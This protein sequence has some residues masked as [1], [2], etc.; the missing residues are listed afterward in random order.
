MSLLKLH[1]R[2]DI[3]SQITSSPNCH[4]RPNDIISQLSSSPKCHRPYVIAQIPSSHQCHHPQMS[5]SPKCHHPPKCIHHFNILYENQFRYCRQLQRYCFTKDPAS[6]RLYLG[7][8]HKVRTH[9]GR[10]GGL[11]QCVR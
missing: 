9:G 5:L 6:L 8:I 11:S 3:I 2:P 4:H 7:V 10:M 1:H